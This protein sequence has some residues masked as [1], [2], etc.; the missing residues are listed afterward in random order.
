MLS[1]T[2]RALPSVARGASRVRALSSAVDMKGIAQSTDLQDLVAD[3]TTVMKVVPVAETVASHKALPS[4]P[5]KMVINWD[6]LT[7]GLDEAAKKEVLGIKSIVDRHQRE[8]DQERAEL[9]GAG[10]IDWDAWASKLSSLPNAKEL[11][12][13]FKSELDSWTFDTSG[14]NQ[15]I[16]Q[17]RAD[18]KEM[19]LLVATEKE[20]LSAEIAQLEAA[21]AAIT[22]RMANI[23]TITIAEL[24]EQDPEMAMEVDDEI[25]NENW[26]P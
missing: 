7:D 14:A 9:V 2:A 1:R 21:E 22:E 6:Y 15:M 26:A 12:D 13:G 25:R 3:G 23:K 17:Y 16:D 11:L 18:I 5:P 20:K 4:M 24:M 8:I 19:E 10:E